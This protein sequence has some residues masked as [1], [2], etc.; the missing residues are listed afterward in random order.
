[1][2]LG[3]MKELML[4]ELRELY[5]AER[6]ALRAYP[7]MRKVIQTKSLREA[8]ERHVEETQSQV[9][10]LGEIFEIMDSRTRGKTCH[11]MQGLIEEAQEHIDADLPPALLEVILVADLQKIEH[12][13][14]AAYGSARAHAEAL[15]LDDAKELLEQTLN[16]EKH[17]ETVLNRIAVN[18]VNRQAVGA[19]Q[20]EEEGAATEAEKPKRKSAARK[21]AASSSKSKSRQPTPASRSEDSPKP[22]VPRG[23]AKRSA[24]QHGRSSS[25]SGA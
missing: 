21:S 8:V 20:E 11:A 10:R 6:L 7:R 9:E 15:G 16:E 12:F 24:A 19:P 14:I 5:S 17:T 25:A 13:E 22:R 18:E 4:E 2:V 23:G 1:M 3:T